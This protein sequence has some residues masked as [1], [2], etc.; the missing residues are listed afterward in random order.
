MMASC[1]ILFRLFIFFRIDDVNT[2]VWLLS[3]DLISFSIFSQT[4]FYASSIVNKQD[5][6]CLK[7]VYSL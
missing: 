4:M 5:S 3:F 1:L 6:L 2:A 7:V